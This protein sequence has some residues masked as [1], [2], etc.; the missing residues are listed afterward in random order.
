MTGGPLVI[1]ARRGGVFSGVQVL[2]RL[3]LCGTLFAVGGCVLAQTSFSGRVVS[4]GAPLPGAVVT[5]SQGAQ[6]WT[7]VTDE[8]GR[9][10]LENVPAGAINL[11][12]QQFG[13]QPLRRVVKAE[14]RGT[15]LDVAMSL[16]PYRPAGQGRGVFAGAGA[17]GGTRTQATENTLETQVSQALEQSSTVAPMTTGSTGEASESF[18]VQGSLSSGLQQQ[19]N[20]AMFA[21][22]P[23][24]MMG[25][26]G[27]PP[28]E[29]MGGGGPGGGGMMGGGGPGGGGFGGRGGGMMG[30]GGGPGGGGFAGRGMGGPGGRGGMMGG[31]RPDFANMTQ[32]EREKLRKQFQDRMRQANAEGFGNRSRRTRD[33]IRG[34]AF[35]TFRNAALDAS[36]YALNGRTVE[37]PGYSNSRYGL[38]LGGPL[39]LGKIFEADKTFFFLNYS[40][41]RGDNAYNSYSVQPL[42]AYRTGDFSSLTAAIYDPLT[43]NPFPNNVIPQN[44]ISS[45]SNGLLSYIPA[46]TDAGSLQNYHY[47]TTQPTNNDTLSFRLNRTLTKKDR[48]AFSTNW[49]RRTGENVQL[50]GWRDASSGRGVNNDLSWS[51]SFS[52]TMI[53]NVHARYNRNFNET[54][55]YFA[56]GTDVSGLLG[57]QGT[58]RDP[59]NYGPPNLT[60]TNY[61]D[62]SD[63]SRSRRAVNTFTFGNGWTF[64]HKAHTLSAGFDFTRTQQN[65][66]ADSNARGTLFFGGLATSGLTADGLPISGTGNDFADFLLGYA[67][68]STI[69]YG[70]PDTYLRSSQYGLFVQDE[71]RARPNLTLNFGLRWDDWEPSTEKYGRLSNLDLAAGYTGAAIVTPGSTSTFGNGTIPEGMVQPDRNN[72]APRIG[73]AYRPFKKK[74]S[75]IRA[76]YSVFY[77]S[78]V[79]SRISGRLVSQPPFAVSS[80]FNTSTASPLLIDNP[81]VG[82]ADTTIKN[83]YAVNPS[84]RLPYAQTWSLSV[85]HDIHN[86]VVEAGYLG[87]KGTAL[88]ISR[89]P[90][91]AAPGSTL[92]SEERR[93][94]PYAVGFTYDSPEGSSIYHAGHIRVMRRMRHGISWMALYTYSKSIDNASTIGGSGN[95]TVLNENNLAAE[96]GLSSFDKRHNLSMNLQASSP[97]GPQGI[98]MRQ[99]NLWSGILMD[100]TLSSNITVSTGTPLTAMASGSVADAAGTGATGSARA[101]ATGLAISSGGSYF[102]TAAFTTPPGDRYG[103]AGRNTIP[104]PGLFSL[105]ASFGRS[106]QIGENSRHRLEGR[107]ETTN[108]FNH[109]NI[110]SYGTTVNAANYGLATAAGATRSVQFTVRLRF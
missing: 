74:R 11:E 101:E 109:I 52:P 82:P 93:P 13:F 12:V 45:I 77:D 68:Q 41:T 79:I 48:L 32:E 97:F 44:R 8:A 19:D 108:L 47:T 2:S 96:R 62:L 28:G 55:P 66:L 49:Q 29:M 64:V 50:F 95:T 86:F 59:A 107:I 24:G 84:F 40:G 81:F 104:G 102:N 65:S 7:T 20:P 30:G 110:T 53:M 16:R 51:R 88:V 10:T 60:F 75:I 56:N 1:F 105:N 22:G 71:W 85:Q 42:S 99:R 18:L 31:G 4:G 25:E 80:T 100:W 87:T 73:L 89:L 61:G 26:G 70:S 39:K 58:S 38:S 43:G 33:Q 14:E 106:W 54:L 57:I 94:I 46:P 78:S 37:K 36:P 35:F 5:A 9:F 27:P 92:T 83:S 76:G 34:G 6:T 69:R 90:N 15:A 63:G 103:N 67:Q 72:F 17:G 23:G 3:F 98:W 21:F 91:R